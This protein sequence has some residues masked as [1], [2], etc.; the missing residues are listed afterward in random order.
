MNLFHSKLFWSLSCLEETSGKV[1]GLLTKIQGFFL[2][3]PEG[4]I[5]ISHLIR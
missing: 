5:F 4:D 2:L 3:F 1:S